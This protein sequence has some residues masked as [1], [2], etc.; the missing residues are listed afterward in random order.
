LN[1]EKEIQEFKYENL[2]NGTVTEQLKI[3]KIFE[4][5]LRILDKIKK[6]MK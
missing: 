5:N 4:E 1:K 2:F 6:G 3:A